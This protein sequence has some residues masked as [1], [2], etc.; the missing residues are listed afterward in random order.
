[1]RQFQIRPMR[2]PDGSLTITV[3]FDASVGQLSPTEQGRVFE[4]A[5]GVALEAA[6]TA[7]DPVIRRERRR[8]ERP[9][10]ESFTGLR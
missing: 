8:A 2:S 7:T 9:L 4:R 5:M 1:M 3:A 6:K 10:A